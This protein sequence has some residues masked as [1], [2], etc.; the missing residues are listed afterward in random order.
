VC[1]LNVSLCSIYRPCT[2]FAPSQIIPIDLKLI[3]S[4][5]TSAKA[6]MFIRIG[7]KRT[8]HVRTLNT[9]NPPRI[10]DDQEDVIVTARM[11]IFEVSGQK[12]TRISGIRLHL[13]TGNVWSHGYSTNTGACK[14]EDPLKDATASNEFYAFVQ[15]G[16]LPDSMPHTASFFPELPPN[17]LL[18]FDTARYRDLSPYA[19]ALSHCTLPI[20]IGSVAEPRGA[21]H[22]RTWIDVSQG[23]VVR[24]GGFSSENGWMVPPPSYPKP[25]EAPRLFSDGIVIET[26]DEESRMGD[27]DSETEADSDL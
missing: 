17:Q 10:V 13:S 6:M 25:G 2:T 22:Y 1:I 19:T 21:L 12:P 27:N 8:R 5:V 7:I 20:T 24:E 3:P 23:D 18:P 14:Y 4:H 26:L 11:G 9:D 16:R 15:I